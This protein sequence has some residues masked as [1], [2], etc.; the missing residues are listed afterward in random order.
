[1]TQ[2]R[3]VSISAIA[4]C[5][6][7]EVDLPGLIA[8]VQDWA[9][10]LI[11]IDDEST[12]R[13]HEILQAA[14]DHVRCIVHPMTE[15]GYA[16]QR[17]AGIAAATGDWLLHLDCDERV[18]ADLRAEIL[19][20]VASTDLRAFR[21]RRLNFFLHRPV[22]NGG[23][24]SWNNPQLARRGYHRFEGNLHERCVIDGGEAHIGQLT[25]KMLHLNDASFAER[26]DKSNRYVAMNAARD[27]DAGKAV[28]GPRIFG[29]AVA[30]FAKKYILQRGFLDGTVG[31][32]AAMHAATAVFRERALVWDRQNAIDRADLEK[33]AHD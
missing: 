26:I 16:G 18:P 4:I 19:A 33:L 1:M 30:T 9:D 8:N 25:H 28:T 23:W 2:D 24:A 12:D 11:V 29:A 7:E 15:D 17:N 13:S 3:S 32:I 22:L 6:N 10:E 5:K 31:L 27:L 21:Y 20:S 14:G